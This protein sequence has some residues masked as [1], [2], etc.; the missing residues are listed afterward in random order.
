MAQTARIGKRNTTITRGTDGS[1]S[2]R[3]HSTDVVMV[4]ARGVVTLNT[5][6]WRTVT[7]KTRMNQAA[8]QFGLG[9]MVSQKDRVWTV[10]VLGRDGDWSK[11]RVVKFDD[12]TVTFKTYRGAAAS[13]KLMISAGL[14]K[15]NK[16]WK[17]VPKRR[18]GYYTENPPDDWE[19]CGQCGCAHPPEFTGDCRDDIN[20]WPSEECVA[21]LEG[22]C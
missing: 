1:V 7:T 19:D 14:F 15:G 12:Y 2:V 13:A 11:A 4:T 20:R 6:G 3:Y 21:A 16:A 8:N 9:F 10:R 5:G 18:A 22:T 17:T